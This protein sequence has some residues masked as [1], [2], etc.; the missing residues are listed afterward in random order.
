[1]RLSGPRGLVGPP[2]MPN[3]PRIGL[4]G[5]AFN[6]A[7]KGHIRMS[8]LAIKYLGLDEVW[9]LV[10]AC[11]PM[12]NPRDIA[13]LTQRMAHARRLCAGHRGV[14]VSGIEAL[15]ASRYTVRT[16]AFLQQ[17]CRRCRFV[18]LMGADN[19]SQIHRWHRWRDLFRSIPIAV[20]GRP[21]YSLRALN[22]VAAK[23]YRHRRV[24]EGAAIRLVYG[25]P[26]A[27]VFLS[28]LY[29][30]SCATF[31]RSHGVLSNDGVVIPNS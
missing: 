14:R 27:W 2:E 10:S 25:H 30:P 29:D 15:I 31:L 11:H 16:V 1:M 8:L 3:R 17:R 7:H 22:G 21:G 5:G 18:W 4:L 20:F 12:K 9:W 24:G 6:P 13:P 19:L 28:A 26:P 23:A